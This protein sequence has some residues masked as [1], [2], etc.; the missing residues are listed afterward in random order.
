MLQLRATPIYIA[1]RSEI[2]IHPSSLGS[3]STI[4]DAH[5]MYFGQSTRVSRAVSRV[6][7]HIDRDAGVVAD[8]SLEPCFAE[9]HHCK[10]YTNADSF[11]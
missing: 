8:K 7:I 2:Q 9:C 5:M 3:P 6:C 11:G 10:L 1:C 4:F